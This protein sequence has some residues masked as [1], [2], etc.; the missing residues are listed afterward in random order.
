MAGIRGFNGSNFFFAMVPNLA[1]LVLVFQMQ[2]V[3][4]LNNFKP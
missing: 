3:Q 4:L 2:L 1:D